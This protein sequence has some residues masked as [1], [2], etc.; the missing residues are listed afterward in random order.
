[1]PYAYLS[2]LS[3]LCPVHV[4][5]CSFIASQTFTF[6]VCILVAA[7]RTGNTRTH[8]ETRRHAQPLSYFLPV[9]DLVC[10]LVHSQLLNVP[11]FLPQD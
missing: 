9:S 1:M 5:E 7:S 4:C 6:R 2:V 3:F 11:V 10:F 8:T